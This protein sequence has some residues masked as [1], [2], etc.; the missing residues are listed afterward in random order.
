MIHNIKCLKKMKYNL[1]RNMYAQ[2]SPES[3][4]LSYPLYARRVCLACNMYGLHEADSI[5]PHGVPLKVEV[6]ALS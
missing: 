5:P 6:D 3:R 4:P 1:N 2:E